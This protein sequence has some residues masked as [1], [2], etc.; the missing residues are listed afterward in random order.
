MLKKLFLNV[1]GR[2]CLSKPADCLIMHRYEM[3]LDR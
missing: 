3:D 1:I 2:F